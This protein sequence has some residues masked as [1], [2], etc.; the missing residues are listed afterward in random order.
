MIEEIFYKVCTGCGERKDHTF[1]V[2]RKESKDGRK[3]KCKVC[4]KLARSQES[5]DARRKSDNLRKRDKSKMQR[6]YRENNKK[7]IQA[8]KIVN[9]AVKDGTLIRHPCE[10]C[11]DLKSNGHHD[12]YD[13]P[14]V[15][16]WLCGLHHTEWHK[17]NGEG[18]NSKYTTE[19]VGGVCE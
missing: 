1:F 12:D 8:H 11:G 5:I 16:R 7:K 3:A 14:L 15:V 2:K 19:T 18:L 9:A 4:V 17:E 10:I 6:R 13:F